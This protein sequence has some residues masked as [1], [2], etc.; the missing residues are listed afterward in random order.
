[1]AFGGWIPLPH[2]QPHRAAR[3]GFRA[4]RGFQ[5]LSGDISSLCS[6]FPCVS[7][8]SCHM[9]GYSGWEEVMDWDHRALRR[10]SSD[11]GRA[12]FDDTTRTPRTIKLLMLETEYL[13]IVLLI[14]S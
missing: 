8:Y 6:Y 11:P 1:M 5:S 13:A 14:A 3:V 10:G 4:S 12:G 9:Y 7:G 2:P